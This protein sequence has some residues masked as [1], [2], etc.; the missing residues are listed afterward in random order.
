MRFGLKE[1]VIQQI[2]D[3]FAAFPE[4]DEAVLYGSWAKGNYRTG[5]DIDFTLKG[6]NM[7]LSVLN[8][9]SSQLD[10]L[11]LPYKFDLSI[12]RSIDNPALVDH[13]NRVGV[14]FYRAED[15]NGGVERK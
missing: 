2:Q 7:S 8:K 4:V 6:G 12:Y 11:L 1:K 15:V 14:S 5:S 10:D 9:I 13:I 3:V